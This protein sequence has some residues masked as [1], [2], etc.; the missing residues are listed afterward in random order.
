MKKKNFNV[1]AVCT[2]II[3]AVIAVVVIVGLCI[4]E[5]EEVIQGQSE[6][7][8]YRISSKIPARVSEIRVSEG[9]MVA[10]GDTL[11]V[12][13]APDI[14]AKLAQAE[15]AYKAAQAVEQK[16]RTGARQEQ[17]QAAYELWQKAI[18]G[19]EVAEKTYNRVNRLFENGVM[20]EQKRDEALANYRAMLASEKAA[21]S[22]Y[23][24]A[25]NGSR[26]E[27]INAASAQ[28]SRAESAISEVSS[29]MDETVLLASAD[30]VVTEIFPEIGELVGSGAPIMNV[31]RVDDMWFT[32]N[33]REDM[34]PGL[35]VGKEVE[36]YVPAFDKDVKVKIT[37]I[38]EVGSFATWKATKALDKFDLKTFE[39]QAYP[40]QP[41]ELEGIRGGM[42]AIMKR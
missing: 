35:T 21:K 2:S 29:Y 10:K 13:E 6:T 12:L 24:M 15:A 34:L 7:S 5:S 16:A 28:V 4:P 31:S 1:I 42:S 17:I 20:A 40:L 30:G 3:V 14:Q 27:D 11:V 37:R 26:H 25:V 18:A 39:L 23:D 19:R 22:Q 36:V 32:F 41:S 38:K 8:D 33:V 9:D